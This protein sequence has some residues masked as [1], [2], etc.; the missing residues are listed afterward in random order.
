M[1]NGQQSGGAFSREVG[2]CFEYP[3]DDIASRQ[4]Q[5]IE[6]LGGDRTRIK[7]ESFTA[8]KT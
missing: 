2:K 4:R 1:A 7:C 5:T 3:F 6:Q 8:K